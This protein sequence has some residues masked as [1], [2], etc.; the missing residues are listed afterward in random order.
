MLQ[1]RLRGH[2]PDIDPVVYLTDCDLGR[3]PRR[4]RSLQAE[5]VDARDYDLVARP[6]SQRSSAPTTSDLRPVSGPASARARPARDPV[7]KHTAAPPTLPGT[8]PT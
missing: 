8:S 1:A 2:A 4:G 7:G 3:L 6:L 5:I